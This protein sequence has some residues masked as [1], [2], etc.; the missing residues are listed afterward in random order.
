[1]LEVWFTRLTNNIRQQL[2]RTALGLATEMLTRLRD[3]NKAWHAVLKGAR[4][5]RDP[6]M[7]SD[8]VTKYIKGTHETQR[9]LDMYITLAQ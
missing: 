2:P 9:R 5:P 6:D 3:I 1:M 7:A 4:A 8:K